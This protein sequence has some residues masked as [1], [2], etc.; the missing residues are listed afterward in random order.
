MVYNPGLERPN[1]GDLVRLPSAIRRPR[2]WRR[3]RRVMLWSGAGFL[4]ALLALVATA[5]F[6]VSRSVNIPLLQGQVI[7]LIEDALGPGYETLVGKAALAA[8][9]V[10]GLV[11]R[12]DTVSVRDTAGAEVLRVPAVLLAVDLGA[13]VTSRD[14]IHAVEVDGLWASI[15]RDAGQFVL[16]LPTPPSEIA[17]APIEAAATPAVAAATQSPAANAIPPSVPAEALPSRFAA[18]SEPIE[19]LDRSLAQFLELATRSGFH[20]M[21]VYD[22]AI[23]LWRPGATEPQRFAR[24][25]VVL[26]ANPDQGRLTATVS[27]SGYS[28]RWSVAADRIASPGTGARTMALTFS[29]VTMADIL[30][31]GSLTTNI[32]FYGRAN[33]RIAADGTIQTAATNIDL[34]SGFFAFGPRAKHIL[35]D[36]AAVRL[37]WDVPGETIFIEPSLFDFGP[38]HAVLTGWIRPDGSPT[39]RRFAFNIE[40]IDALLAPRDSPAPPLPVDRMWLAGT[41]DLD[42][43]LLTFDRASVETRA[44]ALLIAGSL[45]LGP[46]GPS[47]AVAATFTEMPMTTLMQIWPAGLEDGGR[48]WLLNSVT[49]GRITGGHVEAEI[50]AAALAGTIPV[51][52][53]MLRAELNLDGVTFHTFG[54]MPDVENARGTMVFAGATF[55]AD[56]EYGEI[57]APGGERIEVAAAAFAIANTATTVP[58]ARLEIHALGPVSGFGAIADQEPIR[59]LAQFDMPP[60][61]LEGQANARISATWPMVEELTFDEVDHRIVMA[62]EGLGSSRP[63]GGRTIRNG[64]VELIVTPDVVTVTGAAV[65]DGVPANL[66]LAFPLVADVDGLTRVHMV[67]NEDDRRRLGFNLEGFLGGTVTAA[68]TDLAPR[69]IGQHYELDLAAARLTLAPLGWSKPA[70]VPATMSF[71]IV[72]TADGYHIRDVEL[73]GEG[74]SM[75]GEAFL[76]RSYVIQRVVAS[77]FRLNEA[78]DMTLTLERA[79]NG[80]AIEIAGRSFDARNL[81]AAGLTD[82]AASGGEATGNGAMDGDF[83]LHGRFDEL[84]GFQGEVIQNAE[85]EF[86]VVHGATARVSLEGRLGG[87]PFSVVYAEPAGV[88][89][90]EAYVGDG[91]AFFRFMN[92][93]DKIEGGV[94][95]VSGQEYSDGLLRGQLAMNG[96]TVAGEPALA[97]FATPIGTTADGL[98]PIIGFEALTFDFTIAGSRLMVDDALL[99]G[100]GMGATINGW[101]DLE[102]GELGIT[103][104]YIP[105]YQY[106]NLFSRIPLFGLALGGGPREGMFGMTFRIVGPFET[107]RLQVNPLSLLAPGILRKFFVFLPAN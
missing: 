25:D 55:G 93:Y 35:M 57:N 103:G 50:P 5:A 88:A 95:R 33:I 60:A 56:I 40:S 102:A 67:L 4:L 75:V 65:V 18:L 24:A 98:G 31:H 82:L 21:S 87:Q 84:I 42:Q 27:A 20:R 61:A 51:T 23:D 47:L 28:G 76:D 48:N 45:G 100:G 14:L 78:D 22:A 81:L 99:L 17:T 30:G 94:L 52:P 37:T 68:V 1:L 49:A 83:A 39:D 46:A 90:L 2:D 106:N 66:D 69:E 70:G 62:I 12:L 38:S 43:Q 89:A 107:A 8:D 26:E 9:P 54:G 104:T 32:P 92:I 29:Q 7:S 86:E 72:E 10:L 85:L 74:F 105:D 59:A 64:D 96:F 11:V 13:L 34:G 3:A 79:A 53:Q 16:G 101:V 63:I 6:F 58:V 91:G 44:G 15:R 80:F 41:L 73:R 97:Q 77:E 71:D 19:A 36:R